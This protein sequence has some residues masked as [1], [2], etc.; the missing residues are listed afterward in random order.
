MTVV[1]EAVSWMDGLMV[2]WTVTFQ[3]IF[4]LSFGWTNK[5]FVLLSLD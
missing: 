1:G 2:R 5:L 3:F 4:Y